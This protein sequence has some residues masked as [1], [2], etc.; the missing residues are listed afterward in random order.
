L[1]VGAGNLT[2]K[3]LRAEILHKYKYTVSDE[4]VKSCITNLNFEFVREK[5]GGRLLSA[6]EIYD[7]DII[8]IENENF[9]FSARFLSC[10]KQVTFKKFLLDSVNYSFMNS[11]NYL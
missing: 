1:L 2:I 4:T 11:I 8:R 5:K 6:K 7:L 3:E 9:V 10:L